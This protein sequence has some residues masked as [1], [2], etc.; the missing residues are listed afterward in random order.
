[1]IENY[2]SS[3]HAALLRDLS[4]V[5]EPLHRWV[6]GKRE[7]HGTRT[8]RPYAH[9]VEVYSFDQTWGSTALGFPGIGGSAMTRATTVV[10][11]GPDEAC[12]YFG[13]QFAYRVKGWRNSEA[14]NR[15]M[16]A[17]NVADVM[18]A[19]ARYEQSGKTEV[20]N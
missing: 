18:R 16:R 7:A 9:E 15:D 3:I 10:V 14:F 4:E 20:E 8:R 6:D 11:A 19:A 2:A 1:M 12:V 17:Y 13:G 5:E